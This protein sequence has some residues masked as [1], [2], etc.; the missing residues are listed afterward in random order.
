MCREYADSISRNAA[1]AAAMSS[2]ALLLPRSRDLENSGPT[3][4]PSEAMSPNTL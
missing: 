1:M 3:G 4:I 2:I